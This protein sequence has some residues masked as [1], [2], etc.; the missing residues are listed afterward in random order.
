MLN[1]KTVRNSYPL[2]LIPVLLDQMREAKVYTRLD[3]R[4]AYHL[5]RIRDG[6]EWKTAFKTRYGLFEY[7]VMPFGLCNSP[8]EF[9][10]FLNDVFKEYVDRFV[11]VYI[12]DI[13]IYSSNCDKHVKHVSLILQKLQE[14]S[15]FCKLSK[16][17][18]HVQEVEFLGVI[19][20][21]SGLSMA[22][23]KISAVQERPVPKSV[24]D[25]QCFLGFS[26][27]CR[28][29]IAHFSQIV[30]PITRLL[31]KGVTF[32]WTEEAMAAF[33][34]LKRAFCTAPILRHPHTDVPFIV[35]ADAS[36]L[37]IGAVLSQR[38]KH[39]GQ[40]HPV[41]FLSKKLTGAELNYTVAEKEL[42]AIKKALQ[43][44]RHYLW[45][46][47]HSITVYTDHRN[48]QY[49]KTVRQLTQRQMRWMLF[50]AE[51]D[52]IVMF[53]PGSE[54]RKADSLSRLEDVAQPRQGAI[55]AIVSPDKVACAILLDQFL[56]SVAK[57]HTLV[58]W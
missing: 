5:V 39:T 53:R 51:F 52:F 37:A 1:K 17:E 9:Q 58:Q 12:D 38:D 44:W 22:E 50:F 45:G 31:R 55:E 18:F 10:Y 54:N 57:Y 19:L 20:S 48:L 33:Q 49:M 7:F 25:V 3:L 29:F 26:N 11:V 21:P 43:E 13:L 28:R 46:A 32:L 35:D 40:L 47:L 15:L 2:S 24:R 34:Y 16:C 27:Y 42:V 30:S 6:D 8:A 41:A 36:D 14:H 4:G 56:D 23:R